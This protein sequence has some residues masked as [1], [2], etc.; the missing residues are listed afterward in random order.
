VPFKTLCVVTSS[1]MK[2]APMQSTA[3]QFQFNSIH[4]LLAWLRIPVGD[5]IRG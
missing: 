1:D 3:V 2:R 5:I 4:L